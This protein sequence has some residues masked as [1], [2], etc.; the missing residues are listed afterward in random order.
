M[1]SRKPLCIA[2]VGSRNFD[3]LEWV[4]K[5]VEALVERALATGRPVE[6]VSGGARGVDAEAASVVRR[7]LLKG[8]KVTLHEVVPD[9]DKVGRSA[10]IER[11]VRIIEL[12]EIV[13]AFWDGQSRGTWHAISEAIRQ[14]RRLYVIR[15]TRG[16]RTTFHT[17]DTI[18]STLEGVIGPT[19]GPWIDP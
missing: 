18:R 19:L 10:G 14:G 5:G 15:R 1:I 16:G 17:Y 9:W 11:N 7:R 6:I 4:R 3:R 12:A 13:V 2:I 8:G